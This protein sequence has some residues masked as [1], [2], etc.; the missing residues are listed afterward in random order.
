MSTQ[1]KNTVNIEEKDDSPKAGVVQDVVIIVDE[2]GSM[3]SM[4]NE[5]VEALNTFIKEQQTAT[6]EDDGARLS[7]WM[8][9]T[10]VRLIIDDQP[11]QGV[12]PIT[13]YTPEGMTAMNDAIGKAVN[14]KFSK[15]KSENVVC[16][17]ITDGEENSSREFNRLHIKSLIH[18]AE[19]DKKWKF[20]FVGAKDI[21]GE[22]VKSG[23]MP[24]RCAAFVPQ[25]P[26]HLLHVSRAVSHTLKQYRRGT[27]EGTT[28]DINLRQST[29]P[30]VLQ[31]RDA[32]PMSDH[33][34]VP[35][36]AVPP[37]PPAMALTRSQSVATSGF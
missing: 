18:R 25:K 3:A 32:I 27:S 1:T 30:A 22:G 29:A 36:V 15:S 6:V 21:F 4:G 28:C 26:G 9:N 35:T 31:R 23:F 8:F 19:T 24:T 16:M 20:I 2:S 12:S 11:L 33:G 14:L 10:N 37:P 17:V 34:A 5:P 13:D 7:L